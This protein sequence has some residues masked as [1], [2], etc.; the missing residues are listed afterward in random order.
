MN[1]GKVKEAETELDDYYYNWSWDD[2]NNLE[3]ENYRELLTHLLDKPCKITGNYNRWDGSHE[4]ADNNY[5][6]D[7][8]KAIRALI[9]SNYDKTYQLYVTPDYKHFK[10]LE[11]NHDAS[12]TTLYIEPL[13]SKEQEEYDNGDLYIDSIRPRRIRH[14]R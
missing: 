1:S 11:S 5:Y 2:A 8:E 12:G 7:Y 9:F 10:Y 14:R 3:E 13:S 6:R 4:L